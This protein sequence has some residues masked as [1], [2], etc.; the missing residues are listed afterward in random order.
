MTINLLVDK[1]E[2]IGLCNLEPDGT[3]TSVVKM[4]HIRTDGSDFL[5]FTKVCVNVKDVFSQ[6][7]VAD[8]KDKERWGCFYFDEL[9]NR[10]YKVKKCSMCKIEGLCNISDWDMLNI[11]GF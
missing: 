5:T 9:G 10:P 1:E 11:R 4:W 8:E 3:V 6:F 7:R 2:K